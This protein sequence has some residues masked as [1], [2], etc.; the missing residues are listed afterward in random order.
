MKPVIEKYEDHKPEFGLVLLCVQKQ[1][2]EVFNRKR[3]AL[4]KFAKLCVRASFL[5]KLRSQAY[6][7]IKKE[8]LTQVF[9][10]DF[11]EFS[12]NTFFTEDLWTIASVCTSETFPRAAIRILIL[13]VLSFRELKL[14]T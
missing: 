12:K 11:C 14:I 7:F 10:C 3:Y 1:P 6:N 4:K 2:A 13:E 8:T 9:S 5:I